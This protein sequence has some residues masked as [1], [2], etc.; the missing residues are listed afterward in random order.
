MRIK[1]QKTIK[2]K[3]GPTFGSKELRDLRQELISNGL[4]RFNEEVQS[5]AT[6]QE[7]YRTVLDGIGDFGA[8]RKMYAAGTTRRII[9]VCAIALAVV[10]ILVFC[11]LTVVRAQ[12]YEP[13]QFLWLFP[14]GACVAGAF[15]AVYGTLGLLL[16][17]PRR[18]GAIVCTAVGGVVLL[19]CLIIT[20]QWAIANENMRHPHRFDCTD[21]ADEIVSV[22]YVEVVEVSPDVGLKYRERK[23]LDPY[24]YA[25]L[26]DALS[27][28]RYYKVI[29][30]TSRLEEGSE[31]ILIRYASPGGDGTVAA[32]FGLLD[33]GTVRR[34]PDGTFAVEYESFFCSES[35]WDALIQAYFP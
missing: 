22:S 13:D 9:G 11:A 25:D 28:L 24:R 8:L 17:R 16:R 33:P 2:R 30:G 14:F 19:L 12:R 27:A 34:A 31:L 3:F 20:C 10:C 6:E 5:G 35:E 23:A 1:L 32:F 4:D 7:A 21:R 15:L 18:E 26:L 29:H